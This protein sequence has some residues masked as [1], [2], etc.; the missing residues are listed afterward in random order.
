MKKR[1]LAEFIVTFFLVFAGPGAIVIDDI[2]KSI[3]YVGVAITFGLVVM[4][5]INTFGHISGADGYNRFF[6]RGD[7]T[8]RHS[9]YY[10]A[11]QF[12]AAIAASY[13]LK[14]SLHESS[15]IIGSGYHLRRNAT[16]M[17]V[18]SGNCF[19]CYNNFTDI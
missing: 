13:T 12:A 3:I 15:T 4:P 2:T 6:G 9:L 16:F 10:I 14:Q 8:V 11:I 5:L 7:M 19:W 18:F 17:G 1:L